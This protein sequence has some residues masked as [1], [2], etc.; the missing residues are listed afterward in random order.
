[1]YGIPTM[2][3]S[4]KVVQRR[5][6]LMA[7][8]GI[9]F[10]TGVN[11][12]VD[13]TA[14]EIKDESDALLLCMGATWPRNLPIEGRDLAGVHFAMEFLQTWQQ[15]QHGDNIDHLQLSAKVSQQYV[16]LSWYCEI[17]IFLFL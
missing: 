10:K 4:K 17:G 3:L 1:M 9:I 14:Q 13:L 5:L 16:F 2:K 11:I 12:G 15:K 6:D 7:G 8:E